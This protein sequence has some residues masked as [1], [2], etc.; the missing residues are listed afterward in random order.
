MGHF[1][2]SHKK[3]FVSEAEGKKNM[4]EY[5]DWVDLVDNTINELF[6]SIVLGNCEVV[7]SRWSY[8]QFLP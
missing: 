6:T 7:T 4:I 2:T 8:K 5:D 3:F 1:R